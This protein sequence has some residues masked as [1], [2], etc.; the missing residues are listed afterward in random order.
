M[1]DS[2]PAGDPGASVHRPVLVREVL[3]FLDLGPGLVVV[4]GTV[5]G[6]GHSKLILEQLGRVRSFIRDVYRIRP[7]GPPNEDWVSQLELAASEVVTN[8][9]QLDVVPG[10]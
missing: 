9:I 10:D 2:T 3:Q 6:G 4:D 1:S 8:F 5:G 7:G